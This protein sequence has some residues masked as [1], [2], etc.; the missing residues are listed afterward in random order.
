MNTDEAL[1]AQL[2][3]KDEWIAYLER[4]SAETESLIAHLKHIEH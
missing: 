2:Q 3:E 1:L 4:H